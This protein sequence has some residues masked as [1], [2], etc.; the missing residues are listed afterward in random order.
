MHKVLKSGRGGECWVG[1]AEVEIGE[2][3]GERVGVLVGGEGVIRHLV[4]ALSP[5]CLALKL[6]GLEG[7]DVRGGGLGGC[8]GQRGECRWRG[9]LERFQVKYGEH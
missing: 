1:Q 7:A 9:L 6:V 4:D 2:G 8:V 5:P 3:G